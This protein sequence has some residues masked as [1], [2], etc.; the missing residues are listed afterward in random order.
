[1]RQ[2]FVLKKTTMKT[3]QTFFFSFVF[4]IVMTV[5]VNRPSTTQNP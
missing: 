3:S 4:S 1:M 2:A 5:K